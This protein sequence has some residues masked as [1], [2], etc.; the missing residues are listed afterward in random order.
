VLDCTLVGALRSLTIACALVLASVPVAVSARDDLTVTVSRLDV[1]TKITGGKLASF[2]VLYIVRGPNSR[3]ALATDAALPT[4]VWI[5]MYAFTTVE[6]LLSQ[7]RPH[8]SP[9]R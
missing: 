7:R 3:T 1:P 2:G 9:G 5:K 6:A 8:A 4:S